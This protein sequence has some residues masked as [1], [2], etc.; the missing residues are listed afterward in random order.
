MTTGGTPAAGSRQGT[1]AGSAIVFIVALAYLL[2]FRRYGLNLEDEGTLIA[3]A[4]RVYGGQM[5]YRDFH[6]GYTPGVFYLNAA[7]F[8]VFEPSIGTVR[9]GLAV[10]HAA[11]LALVFGIARH[12]LEPRM[13]VGAVMLS[14]AF[15][16]PISTG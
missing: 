1:L 13:A 8:R 7:L 14:V 2:T 12:L 11:S 6:T 10:V 15:F 5:P 16:L 3:Q 9:A 4:Y